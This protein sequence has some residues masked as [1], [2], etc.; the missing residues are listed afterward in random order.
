MVAG[1]VLL[2]FGL[3]QTLADV[4]DPLE[5][6]PA[7]ALLGGTALYL[8]AHVAFRLRNVHRLNTARLLSA[9]LLVALLPAAVEL[10]SL[11]TLAVL[12]AV[13]AALIGY[14]RVRFA[15][16]RERLRHQIS[17]EALTD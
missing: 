8:L 4:D 2:A 17:R 12:A 5:L 13:L 15:E 7:S 9:A 1:I 16:L 11:A 3:K 10:P 14:E 6:V